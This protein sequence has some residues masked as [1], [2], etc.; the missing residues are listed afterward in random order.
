[1]SPRPGPCSAC[2]LWRGA[3]EVAVGIRARGIQGAQRRLNR[4]ADR[5]A[6]VTQEAINDFADEVV[7]H[8]KG[9]VPVDTGKLR[10][11]IEKKLEGESVTVGPRNVDYAG[12]VE[13]GTSDRKSTSLN[14]SN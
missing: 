10:D 9:V 8:M 3:R 12:F 2:S 7:D 5:L 1:M 14:S 6:G 13:Y 11:S 4:I